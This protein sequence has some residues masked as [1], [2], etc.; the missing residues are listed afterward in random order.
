[1]QYAEKLQLLKDAKIREMRLILAKAEEKEGLKDLDRKH[2]LDRQKKGAYE[3][4]QI[5]KERSAMRRQLEAAE[6]NLQVVHKKLDT[7]SSKLIPGHDGSLITTTRLPNSNSNSRGGNAAS[8]LDGKRGTDGGDRLG[9]ALGGRTPKRK[10]VTF[11]APQPSLEGSLLWEAHQILGDE[12]E[13]ARSKLHTERL[14]L[15]HKR[16][17]IEKQLE[18]L[19]ANGSK[20]IRRKTGSTPFGNPARRKS[21]HHVHDDPDGSSEDGDGASAKAKAKSPKRPSTMP[22]GSNSNQST[23]P[24]EAQAMRAKYLAQGGAN[25]LVLQQIQD[26]EQTLNATARSGSGGP[27]GPGMHSTGYSM[28]GGGGG[29]GGLFGGQPMHLQNQ[30][31]RMELDQKRMQQ[32]FMFSIQ[33]LENSIH[34]DGAGGRVG[35]GKRGRGS[36]IR[37]AQIV[38]C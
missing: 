25:P 28:L 26:L 7:K 9:N 6:R 13:E 8:S 36:T 35:S 11:A 10:S 18:L 32:D 29:G 4:D 14:E 38:Y 2:L 21:A 5:E 34:G 16:A 33:H 12:K 22:V 19:K 1:M 24:N 15:E 30:L 27:G 17:D 37:K 20:A 23:M 3:L 31:M